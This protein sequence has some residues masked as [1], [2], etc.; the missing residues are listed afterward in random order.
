MI[1]PVFVSGAVNSRPWP[2]NGLPAPVNWARVDFINVVA[3]R[4]ILLTRASLASTKLNVISVPESIVIPAP[5]AVASDV[6][7]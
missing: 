2:V 6:F 5:S 3:S 4:P 7:P 1:C